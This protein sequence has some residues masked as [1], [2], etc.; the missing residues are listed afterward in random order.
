MKER[1]KDLLRNSFGSLISNERA[2]AAA[3]TAPI[4]LTLIM[5][6]L[7]VLLP[8]IPITT[9][10]ASQSGSSI[11]S[12]NS[13]GLKKT[14]ASFALEMYKDDKSLVVGEDKLLTFA[15]GD[16]D[17]I[18]TYKNELTNLTELR[19]YKI[20]IES[21]EG[22]NAFL[23]GIDEY[24]ETVT[25]ANTETSTEATYSKP[26]FMVFFKDAYFLR[27]V[28][29][30]TATAIAELTGDYK[31]F[32]ANTDLFKS[33]IEI[34]DKTIE[35]PANSA[36]IKNLLAT[37]QSVEDGIFNNYKSFLNNT[38]KTGKE[39]NTL[40]GTLIFGGIYLG[41]SLLMALIIW[42]M[43]RGK[44]NP[45]NYMS[46]LMTFKIESWISVAPALIGLLLGLILP[47][48]MSIKMMFFIAPLGFRVMFLLTKQLRPMQ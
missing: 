5:F 38:Y 32:K 48:A 21:R 19:V 23:K 31:S 39:R 37:D 2:L 33:F 28:K 45:F 12:A 44:N 10:Y 18:Y 41:L 4:W 1:S 9:Y 26:S 15:D 27:I 14:V 42:L 34:K 47:M 36:A 13:Y 30:G 29:P 46:L 8:I 7:A 22:K 11:V 35:K 24:K 25:E 17:P 40:N 3:K 43:T 6:F 16:Q 20:A